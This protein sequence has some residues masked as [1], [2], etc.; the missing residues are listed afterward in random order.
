[1]KLTKLTVVLIL[2][3]N[4]NLALRDFH[5]PLCCVCCCNNVNLL[6][7]IKYLF[8]SIKFK[9]EEVLKSTGFL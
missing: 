6:L 1:M 8:Y 2:K 3:K 4:C 9:K 5:I 7:L